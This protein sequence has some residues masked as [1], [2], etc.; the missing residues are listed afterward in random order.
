M[1]LS[2]EM[3]RLMRPSGHPAQAARDA[4]PAIDFDQ[5]MEKQQ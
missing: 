5:S 1:A 2:P 3:C 4:P